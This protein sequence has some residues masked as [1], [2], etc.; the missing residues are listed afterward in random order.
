[1]S[2]TI[3]VLSCSFL[4]FQKRE[5]NL[6]LM[7]YKSTDNTEKKA[8]EYFWKRDYMNE[9]TKD[10]EENPSEAENQI[11]WKS[12]DLCLNFNYLVICPLW[13]SGS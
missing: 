1:M 11:N 13:P 3:I 12:C 8:Y 4:W 6:I 7:V 10:K 9:G 5:P 2:L